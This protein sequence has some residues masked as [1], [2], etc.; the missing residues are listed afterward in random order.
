[1]RKKNSQSTMRINLTAFCAILVV[2]LFG[3]WASAL[4]QTPAAPNDADNVFTYVSVMDPN[5]VEDVFGKRISDRFVVLQVTITNRSSDFQYLIHDVSLDLK[6]VFGGKVCAN[7]ALGTEYNCNDRELKFELSSLELSMVRGVAEKGQAQ[8]KRNKL[9]RYLEGLGTIGAGLVGIA[10]FGRSYADAMALYNGGVLAAYR[11]VYPDFTINQMNRLSDSAY[12]SNTLIP[13]Q[14]AKVIVAFIPQ[15]IFL[16]PDQRKAFRKDPTSLYPDL[17][18]NNYDP[19]AVQKVNCGHESPICN[20][21]DFR[22]TMAFVDGNFVLELRNLPLTITGVQVEPEEALGFLQPN[23]VV[24]GYISGQF[25]A[26]ANISLVNPPAGVQIAPD[27]DATPEEGKLFFVI[28][29]NGPIPSSRTLNI[30]VFNNQNSQTFPYSVSYTTPPPTLATPPTDLEGKEAGADVTITL[31]GENILTDVTDLMIEPAGEVEKK[32]I[33]YQTGADGK[34]S[35]TATLDM[36]NAKE[37]RYRLRLVNRG[38]SS[39]P[40]DFHVKKKD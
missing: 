20:P 23:P 25:L 13:K 1:M 37:G 7:L 16:T 2:S 35:M 17:N 21:V 24:K 15:M 34:T 33:S 6:N 29:A 31:T 26:G 12:K 14:Q 11:H 18:V 19:N 30:K 40:I 4:A 10:G 32:S 9:L 27:T 36:T 22:R 28:T 8:D 5:I 39:N 38:V 3:P